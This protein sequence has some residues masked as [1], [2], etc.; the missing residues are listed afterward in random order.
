MAVRTFPC[1]VCRY[2]QTKDIGSPVGPT[3]IKCGNC[4]NFIR[5]KEVGPGL[6]DSQVW[7]GRHDRAGNRI[8]THAEVVSD[9]KSRIIE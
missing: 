4:S 1:P 7:D 3:E 2:L 6:Y 8:W 5:V 9:R